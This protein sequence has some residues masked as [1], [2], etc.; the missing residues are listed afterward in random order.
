[1][2]ALLLERPERYGE[3]MCGAALELPQM[4]WAKGWFTH[5]KDVAAQAME[6]LQAL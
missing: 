6:G 4:V 1:L 5:G 2:I 3:D